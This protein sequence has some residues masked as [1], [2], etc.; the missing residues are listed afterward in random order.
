MSEPKKPEPR[1]RPK[2]SPEDERLL[3]LLEAESLKKLLR[4]HGEKV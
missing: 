1:H 3:K 4:E 2:L